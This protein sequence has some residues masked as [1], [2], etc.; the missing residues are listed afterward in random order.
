MFSPLTHD[1]IELLLPLV[2]AYQ[3]FY[4]VPVDDNK[5]RAHFSRFIQD[6]QRGIVYLVFKGKIAVGFC[7]LYFSFSSAKA[8][9]IAILN[10]LYV[11][12]EYRNHG[13]GRSLIE[14]AR[15][16]VRSRNITRLQWLTALNN[17]AAKKLYDSFNAAKSDWTL[18][19]LEP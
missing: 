3:E 19:V 17:I 1:N 14:R 16:E 10:D 7:T 5:N 11:I 4:Q 15:E 13:I 6:T 18:Y 9:E 8:E 2:R 12:P